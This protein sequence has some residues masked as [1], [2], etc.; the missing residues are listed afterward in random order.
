MESNG[1]VYLVKNTISYDSH[2]STKLVYNY[3]SITAIL[4]FDWQKIY[5]STSKGQIQFFK[6]ADGKNGF[7]GTISMSK[8]SAPVTFSG[9]QMLKTQVWALHIDP[10]DL[11]I[12][13][14]TVIGDHTWITMNDKKCW[15]ILGGADPG[16]TNYYCSDKNWKTVGK[17]SV[18]FPP[19]PT[20]SRPPARLLDSTSEGDFSKLNCMGGSESDFLG[21]QGWFKYAGIVYGLH[22]VCHQMANR[23][24][25]SAGKLTV[26]N[27]D[28]YML[29]ASQY[30]I[31]GTRVPPEVLLIVLPFAI[32]YT[33]GI[34]I[35]FSV[36]CSNC[37]VSYPGPIR[38]EAEEAGMSRSEKLAYEVLNLH[39]ERKIILPRDAIF[40]ASPEEL[41]A[42]LLEN[43]EIHMKELKLLFEFK[44]GGL[45]S[46]DRMN[47]LLAIYDEM[48]RPSEDLLNKFAN[49]M[50]KSAEEM[51]TMQKR[52]SEVPIDPLLI[53]NEIN[54]AVNSQQKRVANFLTQSE[55]ITLFGHS[56]DENIGLLDPKIIMPI[57]TK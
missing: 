52:A 6:S 54:K 9:I 7:S 37:G 18:Y 21:I 49:N 39:Q 51:Q 33:V 22:G 46:S 30:G 53:T 57:N 8:E 17:T 38:R 44:A 16:S 25:L 3:D 20:D 5:D 11:P 41:K 10:I 28:G 23:L 34:N 31:Y 50:P 47:N 24:L 35:D 2:P 15:R 48:L 36:Q 32:G 12:I 55:Y 45:I 14:S 4:S 27:A 43:H 1:D 13:G 42:F 40:T 56:P 29:S 19:I 26:T